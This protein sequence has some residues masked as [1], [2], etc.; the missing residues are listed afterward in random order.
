MNTIPMCL[1]T[2]QEIKTVRHNSLLFVLL[3]FYGRH[4][5]TRFRSS[6]GPC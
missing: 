6:S 5:S 1:Q 3:N 2:S 4:V